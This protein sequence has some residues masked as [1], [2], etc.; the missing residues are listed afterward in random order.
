MNAVQAVFRLIDCLEKPYAINQNL[1]KHP[2]QAQ[3]WL[4]PSGNQGQHCR[5][6]SIIRL[7]IAT[8]PGR[9]VCTSVPWD[10]LMQPAS[11]HEGATSC[12]STHFVKPCTFATKRFPQ[13]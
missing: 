8:P 7:N 5:L 6:N 11:P 12:P 1:I 13:P 2:S 3:S 9:A 10:Q 4:H